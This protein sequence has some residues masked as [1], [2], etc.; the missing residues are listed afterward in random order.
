MAIKLSINNVIIFVTSLLPILI[1]SFF[2]INSF[3][4]F[5]LKGLIWLIGLLLASGISMLLKNSMHQLFPE[6]MHPWIREGRAAKTDEL[7]SHDFCEI[8][9]P[10]SQTSKKTRFIDSHGF[11][12]GFTWFYLVFGNDMNPLKPGN[13][14]IIVYAVLMIIDFVYRLVKGC[15][16]F[17]WGILTGFVIGGLLAAGWHAFIV[18]VFSDGREKIFFGIDSNVKKCGVQNTLSRKTFKCTQT[19]VTSPSSS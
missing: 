18:N 9:E 11:F 5:D 4:N 10:L 14:F 16:N 17:K 12:H 8:F 6:A 15:A 3:F 2:I 1:G 19:P 7:P 13:A